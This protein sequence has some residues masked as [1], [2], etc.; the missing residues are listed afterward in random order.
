MTKDYSRDAYFKIEDINIDDQLDVLPNSLCYFLRHLKPRKS[1]KDRLPAVAYLGQSL[2]HLVSPHN[3]PPLL[4]SMG[5]EVHSKAGSQFL[6]DM[7]SMFGVSVS[8]YQARAFERC[9]A[10]HDPHGLLLSGSIGGADEDLDSPGT[11]IGQAKQEGPL[12]SADNVNIFIRTLTGHGMFDGMGMI[13]AYIKHGG[14]NYMAIKRRKVSSDEILRHAVETKMFPRDK[15]K[16]IETHI[17]PP[18]FNLE[19]IRAQVFAPMDYLKA[20]HVLLNPDKLVPQISGVMNIMT[21][22][23]EIPGKYKVEFLPLIDMPS[24]DISCMTSTLSYITEHHRKLKLP[25]NPIIGFDQPL[26]ILSMDVKEMLELDIVIVLG[27][28]HT[29]MSFLGSMGYVMQRSGLA[30]AL[31]LIYG[32]TVVKKMLQGKRYEQAMRAHGLV[33]T[34]IKKMLLSKVDDDDKYAIEAA[35]ELFES[36]YDSNESPLHMDTV[37]QSAQITNLTEVIK[38]V[39]SKYERY[40]MDCLFGHVYLEMYDILMQ[41]L[42]SE[43]LG[44][45]DDNQTSLKM[46]QPYLAATGHRHY[47]RSIARYVKSMENL[48]EYTSKLFKQGMWVVRRTDRPYS[49]VPQDLLIEQTMMAALKGNE[50]L[51]RGRDFNELNHMIWIKS[52]P[53]I[54]DLDLQLRKMTGID[55]SSPEMSSIKVKAQRPA[56]MKQ[57]HTHMNLLEDFF[58]ERQLFSD[59]DGREQR[60]MNLATGMVATSGTNVHKVKEMGLKIFEAVLESDES[61]EKFKITKK[62]LA[63]P[64]SNTSYFNFLRVKQCSS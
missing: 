61:L 37:S 54:S 34:V 15:K 4:V 2:M 58:E 53:V 13:T 48:D 27:G 40:A 1:M 14:F 3:L 33:A 36:L 39:Q 23:N 18:D 63:N 28:F 10:V 59:H 52:R 26:W 62:M 20:C 50:G 8:A 49:G 32:E 45:W 42:T 24:K 9:A 35:N 12:Y 5:T 38:K 22:T 56:R 16:N 17:T 7:L 55:Y 43:R 25:G 21:K 29:Q 64:S 44:L 41:N 30:E 6:T 51:T 11:I 46:M 31:E 60:L 19:A 47:F 57:D